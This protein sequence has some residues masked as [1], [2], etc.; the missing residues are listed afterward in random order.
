MNQEIKQAWTTALR[1]GEYKQTTH[2]LQADGKFC[3][4][5]VLC[6]IYAKEKGVE[7][8]TREFDPNKDNAR[9][10]GKKVGDFMGQ[11]MVPPQEV[12]AW[13]G[14]EEANPHTHVPYAKEEAPYKYNTG[15]TLAA[16]NDSGLTF[17][18][19]ADMIEYF[20]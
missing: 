5:G 4:L 19:M 7:W 18:Q 9:N 2:A 20:L 8:T 14:L 6:N 10:E 11:P 1:S 15:I 16:L 3:C 13:A 17:P 12:A